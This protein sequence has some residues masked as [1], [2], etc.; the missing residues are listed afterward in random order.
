VFRDLEAL[1]QSHVDFCDHQSP[2]RPIAGAVRERTQG[3]IRPA[4]DG[5]VA[6]GWSGRDVGGRYVVRRRGCGARN[7]CRRLLDRQR[8]CC[9]SR[10]IPKSRRGLRTLPDGRHSH[11]SA[12]ASALAFFTQSPDCLLAIDW[13]G[14]PAHEIIEAALER[15]AN[16]DDLFQISRKG[17]LDD[18]FWCTP[19]ARGEVVQL[20]GCLRRNL[21]FNGDT[22][23][24][25]R[26]YGKSP[27]PFSRNEAF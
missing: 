10:C 15:P 14:A 26:I 19:A 9:L 20:L 11:S 5:I 1:P 23:R 3:D 18:L 12:R 13:V 2:R 4:P 8:R 27:G 25:S 24:V 7:G 17:V 21:Y 16:R 6:A 22:V